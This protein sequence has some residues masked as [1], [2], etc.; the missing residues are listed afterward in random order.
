MANLPDRVGT[1][2]IVYADQAIAVAARVL[3]ISFVKVPGKRTDALNRMR[4]DPSVLDAIAHWLRH[5]TVRVQSLVLWMLM[6]FVNNNRDA[7][8]FV[9]KHRTVL[10]TTMALLHSPD[11]V[12][13]GMAAWTLHA[14]CG[15]AATKQ[16][17]AGKCFADLLRLLYDSTPQPTQAAALRC[18]ATTARDCKAVQDRLVRSDELVTTLCRLLQSTESEVA[19]GVATVLYNMVSG[20]K[21]AQ[22]RLRTVGGDDLL[23]ALLQV[24]DTRSDV[25]VREKALAVVLGMCVGNSDNQKLFSR[26]AF[27]M[28]VVRALD[29]VG[30]SSRMKALCAGLLRML[31]SKNKLMQVTAVAFGAIPALV[32]MCGMELEPNVQ[33]QGVAALMHLIGD[34]DDQSPVMM[35]L[36]SP[37]GV[38]TTKTLCNMVVRCS[39]TD[40]ARMCACIVLHK[41]VKSAATNAASAG[42]KGIMLKF[43]PLLPS[44]RQLTVGPNEMQRVYADQLLRELRPEE[45]DRRERDRV[46]REALF[47]ALPRA[48]VEDDGFAERTLEPCPVC[49]TPP[50]RGTEL[51]YLPCGHVFCTGCIRQWLFNSQDTCPS[52]RGEVLRQ[53]GHV[54][55]EQRDQCLSAGLD[56]DTELKGLDAGWGDL[57]RPLIDFVPH[58]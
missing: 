11:A 32:H 50:T 18:V 25:P 6:H 12:T 33:E 48:H 49:Q 10:P 19:Q 53:V 1:D 24:L 40:K 34:N 46:V 14:V 55:K 3:A 16:R 35:A 20:N 38:L 27:L 54:A 28:H 45:T 21:T 57:V 47:D 31:V 37:V 56:P 26:H 43:D 5:G 58:L 13:A 7:Q 51:T 42:V 23:E 29:G 8:T 30:V 2:D 22:D 36:L 17:V 9:A 52:C 4:D 41:M 15:D 39:P 44:L